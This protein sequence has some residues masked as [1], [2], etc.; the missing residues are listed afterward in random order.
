[1]NNPG[2]ISWRSFSIAKAGNRDEENEDALFP[3]SN[4]IH[5]SGEKPYTFLVA[6]GATQTSFSG[7]WAKSL[8]QACSETRLSEAN[9]WQNIASARETWQHSFDGKEIPWHAAEK[10]RQGAFCA[11]IWLELQYAPLL[12]GNAFT[13]KAL[14]VGDC[15]LF[16]ARNQSIYLSL[17]IQETS[18][19]SLSPTLIPSNQGRLE[20]IKG[21][22]KTA[23]G[24]LRQGDQIILA[25]D[26]FSAWIMKQAQSADQKNNILQ[27]I[28]SKKDIF[29][30]TAWINALRKSGELKNDDTTLIIID[31]G[32]KNDGSG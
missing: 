13:W 26:A 28:N 23:R 29:G 27:T 31:A 12:P 7:I 15:C 24:S 18:E 16:I 14:A 9:F 22:I 30:F 5:P 25:S 2:S 4:T 8:V 32:G 10:I 1:L 11:L 19:F 21:K 3:A 17:P 6:D 20:S